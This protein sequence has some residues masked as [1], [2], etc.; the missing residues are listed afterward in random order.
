[1]LRQALPIAGLS[2]ALGLSTGCETHRVECTSM[3]QQVDG[4]DH[5]GPLDCKAIRTNVMGVAQ[6]SE[7][8]TA[9]ELNEDFGVFGM[10]STSSTSELESEGGPSLD[11]ED[12]RVDIVACEELGIGDDKAKRPCWHVSEDDFSPSNGLSVCFG[13]EAELHMRKGTVDR[14]VLH[15]DGTELCVEVGNWD[16]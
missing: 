10:T 9:E 15:P 11:W 7:D 6:D 1:M 2:V 8:L 12:G 16:R 13:Y 14:H 4:E 5:F 3:G